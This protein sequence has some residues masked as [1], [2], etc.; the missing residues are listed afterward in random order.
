MLIPFQVTLGCLSRGLA[1][2]PEYERGL[3]SFS[4]DLPVSMRFCR[5]NAGNSPPSET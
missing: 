1:V 5:G 4:A 2:S 3:G